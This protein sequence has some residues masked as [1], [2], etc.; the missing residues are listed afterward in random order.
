MVFAVDGLFPA[1]KPGKIAL[2]RALQA[3]FLYVFGVLVENFG[4]EPSSPA[5]L[6]RTGQTG[7]T[8]FAY[9]PIQEG[10]TSHGQESRPESRRSQA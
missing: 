2:D 3:F 10:R 6:G 9:H 4:K 8:R 1:K 5:S 7:S